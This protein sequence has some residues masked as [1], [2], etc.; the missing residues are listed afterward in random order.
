[1][2]KNIKQSGFTLAELIVVLVIIGILATLLTPSFFGFFRQQQLKES[3]LTVRS[4]LLDAFHEARSSARF[5]HFNYSPADHEIYLRICADQTCSA[6]FDH[7]ND[8]TTPEIQESL[9]KNSKY[10]FAQEV[11]VNNSH[12]FHVVFSAPHGDLEDSGDLFGKDYV[13]ITL[14]HTKTQKSK[15]IKIYKHSGLIE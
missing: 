1:M 4:T 12:P 5:V 10:Q 11:E 8:V 6:D 2:K 7:D 15:T 13:N 3:E 14:T 9:I